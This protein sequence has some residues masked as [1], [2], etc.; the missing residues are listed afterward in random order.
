MSEKIMQCIKA[1]KKEVE[2]NMYGNMVKK[3]KWVCKNG[4]TEWN[5]YHCGPHTEN[6]ACKK[7]VQEIFKCNGFCQELKIISDK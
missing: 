5:C 7:R 3:I 1:E 6:E 2:E 4:V